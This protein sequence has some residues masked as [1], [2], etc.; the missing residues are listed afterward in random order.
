MMLPCRNAH[1]V[2]VDRNLRKLSVY[3]WGLNLYANR[4]LSFIYSSTSLWQVQIL[5]ATIRVRNPYE[6]N[7][8]VPYKNKER[9][10]AE[11]I[12]TASKTIGLPRVDPSYGRFRDAIFREFYLLSACL[13]YFTWQLQTVQS[14]IIIA[15]FPEHFIG[16]C[17]PKNEPTTLW[18]SWP[19]SNV[20]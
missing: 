10:P 4:V 9:R 1:W 16:W 14:I 17:V 5:N 6:S 3:I 8:V 15:A 11:R 7:S 19:W 12:L 20:S 13:S 2:L 18:D